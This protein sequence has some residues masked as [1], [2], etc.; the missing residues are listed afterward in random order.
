MDCLRRSRTLLG[1]IRCPITF[2]YWTLKG[3]RINLIHLGKVL[4][5][6]KDDADTDELVEEHKDEVMTKD[7]QD[8]QQVQQKPADVE[9]SSGEEP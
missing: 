4:G 1:D 7:L 3:P 6:G 2:Q 5:L 8:L 9:L